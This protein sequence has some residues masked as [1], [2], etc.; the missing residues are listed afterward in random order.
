[1]VQSLHLLFAHAA[2]NG[3]FFLPWHIPTALAQ[4]GGGKTKR[5]W[6]WVILAQTGTD[7]IL[8]SW[9]TFLPHHLFL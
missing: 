8:L 5:K 4:N 3:I 2:T 7:V 6:L 9:R 1:V